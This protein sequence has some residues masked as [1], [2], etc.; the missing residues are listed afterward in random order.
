MCGA[1]GFE[2]SDARAVVL[3]VAQNFISQPP[4][5][6]QLVA[7]WKSVGEQCQHLIIEDGKKTLD[8]ASLSTE[9]PMLGVWAGT[10][11][12]YSTTRIRQNIQRIEWEGTSSVVSQNL[13]FPKTRD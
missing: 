12:T 7:T 9:L 3:T 2:F 1:I 11:A 4:A 8:P 10:A 13:H 6:D 5:L